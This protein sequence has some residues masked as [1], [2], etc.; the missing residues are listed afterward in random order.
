MS[1]GT[2]RFEIV[3]PFQCMVV[4]NDRGCWIWQGGTS[5]G[6]GMMRDGKRT[7]RTHR[8]SWE[9]YRGP[10]PGKF[11]VLHTCDVKLCVNPDHLFLGTT[12][13]N[14][15]DMV[16]KGR[17]K[18]GK[19]KGCEPTILDEKKVWA[20]RVAV[21]ERGMTI[22][23]QAERYGV[24]RSAMSYAVNGKTWK[25]VPMPIVSRGTSSEVT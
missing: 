23:S 9:L 12:A 16:A 7:V 1:C 18:G 6:Y 21:L 3:E 15:R 14:T 2:A 4:I 10:I 5:N 22:T 20:A 8:R 25:A 13:D 19:Q 17:W 24:G 11:H